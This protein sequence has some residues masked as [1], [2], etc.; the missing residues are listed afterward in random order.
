[1]GTRGK[2]PKIYSK[3]DLLRAMKVT[4]SIMSSSSDT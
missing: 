1:M 2:A 3:E 4:K